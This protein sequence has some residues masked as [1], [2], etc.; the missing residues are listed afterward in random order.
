[1]SSQKASGMTPQK[2]ESF[3]NEYLRNDLKEY[4]KHI[5]LMNAEIM[6]Y[7]QLK[8]MIEQI[9]TNRSDGFKTQVDIGGNCF[10]QAKVDNTEMMLVNVGLNHFVEFT[11]DEALKFTKFK[12]KML[13]N[14]VD[15][16]REESIKT[17]ANIKL[18]LMCLG[19]KTDLINTQN[20]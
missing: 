10:V 7:I 17:R 9:Q 13:T 3:V 2:L 14:Q 1:M 5:N 12:V 20:N 11:L 15:V 18:A 19:E 6:E 16:I 4:E 8:S